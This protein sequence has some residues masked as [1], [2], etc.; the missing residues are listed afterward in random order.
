[1]LKLGF[2]TTWR[3]GACRIGGLRNTKL[4][5]HHKRWCE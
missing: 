3:F 4:S 1:M 5:I 2:F